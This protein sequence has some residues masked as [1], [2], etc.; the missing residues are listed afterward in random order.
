M[1]EISIKF[2]E[3]PKC[4]H[5]L[6]LIPPDDNDPSKKR[7]NQTKTIFFVPFFRGLFSFQKKV[8]YFLLLS[9]KFGFYFF[10]LCEKCFQI[11]ATSFRELWALFVF[12]NPIR[13]ECWINKT[14]TT[15]LQ[16]FPSLTRF[17]TRF[18][19]CCTWNWS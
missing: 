18:C 8:L 14:T 9:Y 10:F 2:Q 17:T 19:F 5:R 6:P 12:R 1:V 7:V 11:M 16:H 4:S 15:P 3:I 13:F